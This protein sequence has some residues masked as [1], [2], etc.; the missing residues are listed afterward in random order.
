MQREKAPEGCLA[1]Q[2]GCVRRKQCH[3]KLGMRLYVRE[4]INDVWPQAHPVF[5]TGDSVKK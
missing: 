1:I 3:I 4:A 5:I 2:A